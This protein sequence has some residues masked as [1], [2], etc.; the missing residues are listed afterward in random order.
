MFFAVTMC[1]GSLAHAQSTSP[2]E[3]EPQATII[4]DVENTEI[5]QT[6][7]TQDAISLDNLD[8]AFRKLKSQD[9]LQFVLAEAPPPP[10]SDWL[11]K[12]LGPILA[13]LKAISPILKV[14]FWVFVAGCF[15]LIAYIVLQAVLGIRRAHIERREKDEDEL[16]LYRPSQ[17][18]ARILLN[19]VDALAAKGQY[20]EAVHLLLYRSIQDIGLTKPNMIKRSLTSREISALSSLSPETRQAFTQIA[21]EV[22]RSHFGAQ[23]LDAAA[24]QRCRKAYAQF[25][26]PERNEETLSIVKG[27]P[28]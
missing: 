12:L 3:S 14:V 24:F 21:T 7:A 23:A 15:A 13:F 6:K 11:V 1:G 5:A 28:A 20:A 4:L 2:E 22:E 9:Q 16:V 17:K 25:A 19:A 27:L 26:V 8:T 10:K 18:K